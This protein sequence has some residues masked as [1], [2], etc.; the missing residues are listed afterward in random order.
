MAI[1]ALYVHVPFCHARC[2]Y[3]DFDSRA[4]TGAALDAAAA[5]Y[6]E[7]LTARLDA[8]GEAGL[9]EAV[10]TAYIGGGTP[11]VLGPRLAALVKAI[12]RWCAPVELTCEANPESCDAEL[13]DALARAD[14]TRVSL[15]VQSLD[16]REL[17]AIG[18]VHT[19][20]EARAAVARV[21]RSGLAVSCDLMCGL[22]GQ[23]RESWRATLEGA[24]AL[25]PDHLSV[26]PL[27]LEEGTPLARRAAADPALVPDEDFQAW[28][29][30]EA[31][32]VFAVGGWE[33]Y[34]VAS[35]ARPGCACRHNIAYW[36][37]AS[38]LG[39]GR[40][41]SGMMSAAELA[42]AAHL[43]PGAA[44]AVS[45]FADARAADAFRVRLTQRDDAGTSFEIEVLDAREACAE[46]LML[47]MRMTAGVAEADILRARR[48]LGADDVDR[49][50]ADLRSRGLVSWTDGAP[51]TRRLQP[52]ERGWLMGN[53]LFGRLW[54][55]ADA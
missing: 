22:P 31:R 2:A 16:D 34:E 36:T 24:C 28:C 20:A 27:A 4:L 32:Q 43:F 48:V 21:R 47:G 40:S 42:R 55:L 10:S 51:G 3:C 50:V 12:R 46:D 33:P 26:Y 37:G 14:V 39:I 5:R 7:L 53:E 1:Q 30:V 23:T 35:Y 11:S 18:R 45:A 49:V 15:G 6:L 17:R 9:L 38:Y 13:V 44:R 25:E 19:A 29:M 8:L 52:T 41:A 54:G